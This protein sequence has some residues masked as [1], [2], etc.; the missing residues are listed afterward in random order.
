MG[1]AGIHE[2]DIHRVP[3]KSTHVE[4][5]I[6]GVMD[7]VTET[8][9]GAEFV[10]H[11]PHEVDHLTLRWE[12]MRGMALVDNQQTVS[13]M[14][15]YDDER[16]MEV[17]HVDYPTGENLTRDERAYRAARAFGVAVRHVIAKVGNQPTDVIRITLQEN[18]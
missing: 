17:A 12:V 7:N 3:V 5:R 18:A 13:G 8:I 9:V 10:T 15:I 16:M 11:P 4:G 14:T 6:G 1:P 2:I